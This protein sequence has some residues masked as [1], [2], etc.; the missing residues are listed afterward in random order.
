MIPGYTKGSTKPLQWTD[1]LRIKVKE[2]QDAVA[3]CC[4]IYFLDEDLPIFLH[5]DASTYGVG[6]Y[7]FQQKDDKRIPIQFLN[8]QLNKTKRKWNTVEKEMYTIFY[9]YEL[10]QL[11]LGL[12]YQ[13]DNAVLD[14]IENANVTG[15]VTN[16]GLIANMVM[17]ILARLTPYTG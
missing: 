13:N 2:L 9:T 6:G 15:N 8:K 12:V 11:G 3:N 4:K 10:V 5:T 7:L 16:D 14:R 17:K 1:E